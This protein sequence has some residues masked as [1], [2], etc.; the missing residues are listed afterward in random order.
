[1]TSVVC[2]GCGSHMLQS[3]DYNG[4]NPLLESKQ[5]DLLKLSNTLGVPEVISSSSVRP[6]PSIMLL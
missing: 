4:K 1:M 6:V 2:G 5:F 3:Y